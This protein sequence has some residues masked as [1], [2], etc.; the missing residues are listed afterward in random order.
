MRLPPSSINCPR[1]T[2]VSAERKP[3]SSPVPPTFS[4]S[5]SSSGLGRRLTWSCRA[6][7]ARTSHEVAAS[8]GLRISDNARAWRSVIGP[9]GSSTWT[10]GCVRDSWG[11]RVGLELGRDRAGRRKGHVRRMA[12][13]A[14]DDQGRDGQG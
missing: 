4:V 1:A 14:A 10:G 9:V 2:V 11:A 7:A 5:T 8:S 13:A 6:S 3:R 12:R